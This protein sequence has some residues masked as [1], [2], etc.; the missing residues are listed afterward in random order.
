VIGA[1]AFIAFLG[2]AGFLYVR[3]LR[4]RKENPEFEGIERPKRLS[5]RERKLQ[6]LREFEDSIPPR[7]TIEE[8]IEAE[9]RDTGVDRIPGGDGVAVPIRL[10]VF[11]RDTHVRTG[12]ADDGL[13]FLV[14][15]G[16][17]AAE[18]T[19]D[20]VML[21]CDVPAEAASRSNPDLTTVRDDAGAVPEAVEPPEG[22]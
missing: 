8:L 4:A 13:R 11:H 2:V 19:V 14:T 16:V 5:K 6:Q 10:K 3:M 15:E 1:I 9:I 12:C 18:A 17:D 7:P 21:V 20:D 22:E